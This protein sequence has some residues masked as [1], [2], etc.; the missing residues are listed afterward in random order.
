[1]L[2][3]T[4]YDRALL[5]GEHG[6]AAKMAMSILVRM[7]GVHGASAMLD[8]T[9]AHIDST[10]YVGDAGLEF[11]ERLA[12]LGARVAVPSTANVSGVDEH[13]WREWAVPSEWARQAYRQMMAYQAMGCKPTWT[14]APYQ[15][16]APPAFGEQI[17]WGESNA[18]AFANSVYGARTERYPDL[19]DI[20]AAITGR[21]PAVGLHLTENRAGQVLMRLSGV[22]E[23][24]QGD[25]SFY[26]V[27]GHLMGKVAQDRVP[28]VTGLAVKPTHDQLKALGA[29]AA[30]SGT[31]AL[32]HLVGITPEA[33]TLEAAFQGRRPERDVEVTLDRLREARRELTTADG[34]GVDLV[35]LGSPHF[36]FTEFRQ[37]ASLLANR[38]RH[39]SVQFLVT[40]SRA[41]RDLAQAA[42]L[43][44]PLEGFGGR[45]TVD[46]CIL[47]TP[48][49]PP[50]I[51]R[52]MTNSAKFAYYSPGLLG[53]D[54]T[55][56][57][58]Q[59]CVNSAVEGR[60]VRD[61]SL[62]ENEHGTNTE[63]TRNGHGNRRDV[64]QG[65][66]GPLP[67]AG[68]PA[69]AALKG[70]PT[71]AVQPARVPSPI[72]GRVLVAG[73]AEAEVLASDEPLSFW[74][75]YDAKTGE[76]IDRRHPL[77]G[78]NAAGKVLAVPF[79]RGSSTTTAILLE[80]VRRGTAPAAIVTSQIDSFLALASIVADE[81]YGKPIPV[82]AV[83]PA[84]FAAL[85]TGQ[86]IELRED[87]RMRIF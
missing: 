62:W 76:L 77:A 67:G 3:L 8:I 14:C 24:L 32:F 48:M 44:D 66:P 30:S 29:A 60:V 52:L 19:L 12:S 46:T 40:S 74:G 58:L 84:D 38:T 51:R 13:H 37:L 15:T 41:V 45:L 42:G 17:A 18:I 70:C 82:F 20:C 53:T 57:S 7:A 36:S 87:G 6:P 49:L 81:L 56:G 34:L 25:D 33:P 27:L 80:A 11:A 1:V 4:D 35:V 21:V 50:S 31:V 23:R 64:A 5:A 72:R 86:R 28:V 83:N 85:R 2:T 75:G 39:P 59:D 79:T 22:P 43:L 73:T 61:E 26:P 54:V 65:F 63:R 71:P 69:G 9:Q 68:S 47:A 78:A 55:F 16:E 10:I